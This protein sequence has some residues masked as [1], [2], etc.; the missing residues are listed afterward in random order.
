MRRCAVG[1][2]LALFGCGTDAGDLPG[3]APPGTAVAASI[4]RPPDAPTASSPTIGD[5]WAVHD[6]LV[7]CLVT[8]RSCAV[9]AFTAPGS[10]ARADWSG[11]LVRRLASGLEA[12]APRLPPQ[13][14]VLRQWPTADALHVTM[15]WVD[16]LVLHD[17][18]AGRDSPVV[19][20]DAVRTSFESWVLTLQQ[21]A[22]RWRLAE[23]VVDESVPGTAPWCR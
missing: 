13:R 17:V 15:C 7:D 12:A 1:V 5:I 23:R 16:D 9:D 21:G 11:W 14:A 2:L 22:P 10:P 4:P 19:V 18:T 20:D 8:P 6:H 3:L